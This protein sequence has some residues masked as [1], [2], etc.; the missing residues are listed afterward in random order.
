M[1]PDFLPTWVQNALMFIG[2]GA[3]ILGFI[4]ILFEIIPKFGRLKS[5]SER[6]VAGKLKHK[7][8]VKAAIASDIDTHINE[9]VSDLQKELP[10]GW[11]KK[12]SI[13]WVKEADETD[14]DEGELILRIQPLENQDANFLSGVYA[15]FSRALFPRTKEIIPDNARKAAVLQIS[16]R[17]ISD[18]KPYLQ[19][20][21]EDSFLET[22][23]REDPSIA[24]YLG[25]YENLDSAGFFT[26]TFLREI[27]EIATKARFQELRN[28]MN[29]EIDEILIHIEEF[30]TSLQG[31]TRKKIPSERWSRVGPATSYAFLLVARPEHQ[32][33]KPYLRQVQKQATQGIERLYVMCAKEQEYF[34]RYVISEIVKLPEYKLVEIFNLNRDYRGT[35]GGVGALFVVSQIENQ[36]D[37]EQE[38]VNKTQ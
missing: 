29:Q 25:K 37:E 2:A 31:A 30:I 16:H 14:L 26:G 9:V 5:D 15:F 22:A 24:E 38:I 11:I 17:T 13:E 27:H 19:Q 28:R 34:A 18:K 20:R 1:I 7:R 32:G 4:K 36:D 23:V 33:T 8:L 3:L 12:A 6:Y 35:A 21:F 10:A